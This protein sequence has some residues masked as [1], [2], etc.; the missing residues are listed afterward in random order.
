MRSPFSTKSEASC[1]RTLPRYA[2]AMCSAERIMC[3]S[4]FV[5]GY[6]KTLPDLVGRD[7]VDRQG[8]ENGAGDGNRTHATSLEGWD[9]TVELHPQK[10]MER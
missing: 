5:A 10:K 9:S 4:L 6:K 8:L 3:A 7:V 1:S 2:L